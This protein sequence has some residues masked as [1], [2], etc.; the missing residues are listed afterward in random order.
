MLEVVAQHL[1]YNLL[2]LVNEMGIRMVRELRL[3]AWHH[4]ILA[5]LRVG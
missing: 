5:Y 3:V 2:G 1:G 4:I